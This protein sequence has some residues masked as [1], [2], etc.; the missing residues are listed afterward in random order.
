MSCFA[1][2]GLIFD[3]DR[4]RSIHYPAY[5]T[6]TCQKE[7]ITSHGVSLYN[8]SAFVVFIRKEIVG[9]RRRLATEYAG[10]DKLPDFLWSVTIETQKKFTFLDSGRY[11]YRITYGQIRKTAKNSLSLIALYA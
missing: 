2:K 4:P 6:A 5:Y 1:L 8:L 11:A 3:G 7:K 9:Q 10:V